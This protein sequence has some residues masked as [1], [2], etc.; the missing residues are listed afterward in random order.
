MVNKT[1]YL[2]AGIVSLV[3]FILGFLL[4]FTILDMQLE[5][6]RM[7]MDKNELELRNIQLELL[8]LD[9]LGNET[10]CPYLKERINHIDRKTWELGN[11]LVNPEGLN[12]KYF[13]II[14]RRYSIS[15]IE[16]WLF[17]KELSERCETERI[18]VLYFFELDSDTCQAQGYV[19]DYMV[20]KDEEDALHIFAID[21]NL[22]EPIIQLMVQN[23]NI[24]KA[25]TIVVNGEKH[26]GLKNNEELTSI[27]C[28]VND[29][30]TFCQ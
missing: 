17:S 16:D 2:V 20:E 13:D 18:N 28:D 3:I 30:L 12:E 19:L 1:S 5:D 6:L 7:E 21:R 4:G 22:D 8:F 29:Q 15:L 25:P 9:M 11:K 26:E 10:F 14:K 27:F 23:Y 24:T